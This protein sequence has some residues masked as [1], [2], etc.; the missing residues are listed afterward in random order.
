MKRYIYIFVALALGLAAAGALA[1]LGGGGFRGPGAVIKGPTSSTDNAVV[2]FNGTTGK[3]V[4]NSGV[5]IDDSDRMTNSS[6]PCF[7]AF[8]SATDNDQTGAGAIPTIDFDTEVF[9]QGNDF[10]ADTFTAPI[11]GRYLFAATV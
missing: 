8:N 5:V 1:Q 2:R 9:D 3:R 7:L 10:T 11:T 6:Q 4:Q